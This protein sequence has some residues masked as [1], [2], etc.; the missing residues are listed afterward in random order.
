MLE[1]RDVAKS[2]GSGSQVTHAL[3]SI[4]FSIAERELV[5]VVGP[6]G[7]GKTT[8]LKCIAGLM[9]PTRGEVV[10][11]GER[12]TEPPEEMAVVFQ[13]YNRSLMPWSTVRNNV[14]LPL[15]HKKLAKAERT[16]LVEQAL[17]AVGLTRFIDHYPWQL[18]G[19][20]QQRVAIARAL[21]Y[22]PS[23][24]LMDEPFASVDA[25][26]RGDLE[27]L[28][29]QVRDEFGITIL[30]V[31][32][33]IDESVYLSDRIVVLTHAPT[34]VKELVGVDLPSPRDQIATKELP[35][36]AHL[37]A[38]VYRLVKH[39]RTAPPVAEAPSTLVGE[40]APRQGGMVGM[41]TV[42][43]T[44]GRRPL[45]VGCAILVVAALFAGGAAGAPGKAQATVSLTVGV[46]PIANTLP[47]DLGIKKGFFE[48]QGIEIKKV[49]AQSGNDIMLG[50]ANSN[51]DVG[52]AGWVPAMIA[53]D[54]RDPHLRGGAQRGGE[55]ESGEQLAEHPRQGVEL[56]SHAGRPRGQDDRRQRPEGRRRG[57]DPGG[58][59]E[60]RCRPELD[61]APRAAVPGDA[62]GAEQ[63]AGRRDLDA[64][65][66][67]VAGDHDRRGP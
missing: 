48:Q 25:Q 35:E 29:L 16:R 51:M 36:F 41:K 54:D 47:L 3:R 38:Y 4:S 1:I 60:E 33:D 44:P 19:G 11:H 66:V 61:Q 55:H 15:R 34:V 50:L 31:T 14:L 12:V 45:V 43:S 21:A 56:D 49:T 28:V 27:D 10:L 2:Y 59:R 46:L 7:C 23:I 24:L 30:F 17:E 32:H 62:G 8:L 37:R 52:F 6:S 53:T 64:G 26:T 22:Q 39:D 40:G 57:D 18:S 9:R 65:A 13:E 58:A 63:R 67:P 42:G 20:M 5:C